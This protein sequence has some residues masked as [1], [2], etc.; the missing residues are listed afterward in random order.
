M[1]L[2]L[3]SGNQLELCGIASLLQWLAVE[4]SARDKTSS[5][6]PLQVQHA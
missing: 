1:L 3:S 5:I 2:A 4:T 6:I